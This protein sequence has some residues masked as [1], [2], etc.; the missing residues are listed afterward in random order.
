[1]AGFCDGVTLYTLDNA[2]QSR[3]EKIAFDTRK[4]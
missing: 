3:R 1:M 2:D 4:I